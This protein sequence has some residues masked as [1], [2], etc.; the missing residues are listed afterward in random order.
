MNYMVGGFLSAP[1]FYLAAV[2]GFQFL[3]W[4]RGASRGMKLLTFWLVTTF[5]PLLF[6]EQWVQ[7]RLIDL[8]PIQILSGAG[9]YYLSNVAASTGQKAGKIL[10]I[11][12]VMA[13]TFALFNYLLRNVSFIPS[14]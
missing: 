10:A 12:F 4:D 7:W 5:I 1:I 11:I 9:V 6:V 8:M 3:I 13:V 14:V 2:I